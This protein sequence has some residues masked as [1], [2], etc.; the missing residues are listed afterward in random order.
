[1]PWEIEVCF[2]L[3]RVYLTGLIG[4]MSLRGARPAFPT[5]RVRGQRTRPLGPRRLSSC[6]SVNG[7]EPHAR[8]IIKVKWRRVVEECVW[9]TTAKSGSTSENYYSIHVQADFNSLGFSIYLVSIG[10]RRT[11]N[12]M[13]CLTLPHS[14]TVY[15]QRGL[16]AEVCIPTAPC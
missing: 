15:A 9:W 11:K 16:H 8:A 4:K 2:S 3:G 7:H 1:M 13:P 6:C 12:T 5:H 10:R 14:G